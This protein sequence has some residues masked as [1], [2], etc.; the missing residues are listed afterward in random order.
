LCKE[1]YHCTPDDE[2]IA[3]LDPIIK[4]W[5]FEHWVADQMDDAELAKNHAYLVASFW[6]PEAVK[7]ITGEGG[8]THMSSDEDLIKSMA[9]V[10]N[11][12][13]QEEKVDEGK[14]KRKRKRTIK[15]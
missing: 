8:N 3:S 6:N 2:R 9:M 5:M 13:P 11:S 1:V 10:R 4:R 12:N 14:P 15:V 7:K